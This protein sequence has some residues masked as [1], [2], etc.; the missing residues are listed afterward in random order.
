MVLAAAHAQHVELQSLRVERADEGVFL[1]ADM[2]L[3]LPGGVED[4]LLKGIPVHFVAQAEIV[5]ERWYWYD[6]RVSSVQRHMRVAYMPLTRRWRLNTSAE[7]LTDVSLG[8]SLTQHYDSLPEVMAALSRVP[9]WKIA[10]GHELEGS[11][12]HI[13]RFSFRLDQSQLP[14]TF[15]IGTVGRSAWNMAVE[16]QLDLTQEILR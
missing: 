14:R 3:D 2:D 6:Q 7:P 4:A 13:L 11:G 16:R 8:V 9:R 10:P 1:T 12:R 15:Q 5:R